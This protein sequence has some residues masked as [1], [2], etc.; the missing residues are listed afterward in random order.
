MASEPRL[1]AVLVARN[2]ADRYL[3]AVLSCLPTPLIHVYD[4][5]STDKTVA[6]A[7]SHGAVVTERPAWQPSFAEHEGRFRQAAWGAFEAALTPQLG[8]WVLA[9]DCDE[10]LVAPGDVAE[11]V[12]TAMIAADVMWAGAVDVPIP[13]VF[14]VR[15]DGP[16]VRKDGFWASLSAPRL[17]RYRERGRFKNQPAGCGSVPTYVDM[18]MAI[19]GGGVALAHYG[20]A[21]AEDR[22]AKYDRY[23]AMPSHGHNPAHIHSILST[24]RVEPLGLPAPVVWRGRR[25][26][27]KEVP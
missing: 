16:Y 12:A 14:E 11:A 6:L 8:D 27:M 3:D 2:E 19:D 4:D 21:T 13:E 24:P 9:L 20:Y 18:G 17:F 25:Q 10:F 15:D 7:R 22:R 23:M 5:A 1:H 26:S